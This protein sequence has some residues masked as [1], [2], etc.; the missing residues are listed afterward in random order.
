[1]SI[2]FDQSNIASPED[3]YDHDREFAEELVYEYNEDKSREMISEWLATEKAKSVVFD[4]W[5]GIFESKFDTDKELDYAFNALW[6]DEPGKIAFVTGMIAT[7]LGY[8]W[9]SY[10]DYCVEKE[11]RYVR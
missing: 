9:D 7:Q 10:F 3:G 11:L 6:N 4:N 8:I 5:W 1:M 2:F